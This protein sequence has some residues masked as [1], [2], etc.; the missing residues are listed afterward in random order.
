[1]GDLR[2]RVSLDPQKYVKIAFMTIIRGLGLLFYILLGFRGLGFREHKNPETLN[3]RP[4]EAP[5][6]PL[7][8]RHFDGTPWSNRIL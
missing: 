7:Y 4:Q 2:F 8:W 5:R 3:P 1:M 6:I